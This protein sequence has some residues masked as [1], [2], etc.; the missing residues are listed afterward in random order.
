MGK[1]VHRAVRKQLVSAS[2]LA[3]MGRCERLVVFEHL[4]GSRRTARQKRARERGVAEHAR[5]YRDGLASVVEADRKAVCCIASGAFG[6]AWQSDAQYRFAD[7]R[8]QRSAWGHRAIGL[9]Y[10]MAPGICRA[11][12]RWPALQLAVCMVLGTMAMALRWWSSLREVGRC[13]R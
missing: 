4:Y 7:E 9:Y 5:F 1:P 10:R 12:R 11:L 3:Q 6:E 8:L 13:Q 2:D